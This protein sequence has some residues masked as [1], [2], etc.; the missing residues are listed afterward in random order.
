MLWTEAPQTIL[1]IVNYKPGRKVSISF[2]VGSLAPR[3]KS[4]VVSLPY[5]NIK[6]FRLGVRGIF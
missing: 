5:N 3:E 4:D 1:T 6:D 2:K